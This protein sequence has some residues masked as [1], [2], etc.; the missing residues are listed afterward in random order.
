MGRG[1]SG[2]T[3]GYCYIGAQSDTMVSRPTEKMKT[4]VRPYSLPCSRAAARHR[5]HRVR[6]APVKLQLSVDKK[7]ELIVT[8]NRD[9]FQISNI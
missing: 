1:V 6:N 7:K 9:N 8:P 2:Q 3:I 4:R 5:Q